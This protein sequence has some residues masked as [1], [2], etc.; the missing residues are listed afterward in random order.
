MGN[1]FS[2]V[3]CFGRCRIPALR[4]VRYGLYSEIIAKRPIYGMLMPG[5]FVFG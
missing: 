1:T 5:H 2:S 4:A 3:R